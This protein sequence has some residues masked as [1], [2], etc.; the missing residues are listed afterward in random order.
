MAV[1]PRSP[2]IIG[3]GRRTWHP[4]GDA[5]APEP[6][7][8]W[9]QVAREAA[10]DAGDA[11]LVGRVDALHTVHCMS[12]AYDDPPG[13]LAARLGAEPAHQEMSIL[14][15]TASQR[16]VNAAAERMLRGEAELAL[17]VGAEALATRR[18]IRAA[19]EEP[20]WS[21]PDPHDTGVPV[22]LDE[23]FWPTEWAHDVIQPV[24]TFALYDSARRAALGLD[25]ATSRQHDGDLL[26]QLNATATVNPHA[27]FRT[28]RSAD[29]IVTPTSTNRLVAWP[30]TKYMVAV[31]DVDMAS[32]L[33]VATHERADALGVPADQRVYLRGWAFARDATHVAE[34]PTLASSEAMRVAS[35]DALRS[36]GLGVDDVTMFDLYSCFPSSVRFATDALGLANDDGRPLSLTGGLP[37]HGGPSS[38]YTGHAIA[39]VVDRIR[40]DPDATALVSGVGMHMTKHVWAAYSGRPGPVAPPDVDELQRR[41]DATAPLRPVK[42]DVDGEASVVAATVVHDRDGSPASALAVVELDDGTRA[43]ARTEDADALLAQEADEWVG[44]RVGVASGPDQRNRLLLDR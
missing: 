35:S 28:P 42:P 10:V 38:G 7:A 2:C 11:D 36:A 23:W 5:L 21:H 26:E 41:V 27:W 14:A 12:W 31:M 17:V 1:D 43:Y 9:E 19:G 24:V 22:D 33:L 13:R 15:G 4:D 39:E 29:E 6:L 16:M 25:A 37:Y 18:R 34:R 30:Y 32:A 44:R 40:Q 20:A 3:V 8:M